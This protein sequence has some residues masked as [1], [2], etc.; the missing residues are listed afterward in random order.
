MKTIEIF[1]NCEFCDTEFPTSRSTAKFCSNTCRTKANNQR[2]ENEKI[3]AQKAIEQAE[4]DELKRKASED[5]KIKKAEKAAASAEKQRIDEQK[6][7]DQKDKEAADLVEKQR[8]AD[9]AIEKQRLKKE[10]D[11]KQRKADK[12][13]KDKVDKLR[14]TEEAEANANKILIVIYAAIG[15]YNYIKNQQKAP[16]INCSSENA[17]CQGNLPSNRFKP[18][19]SSYQTPNFDISSE[20]MQS[21][22]FGPGPHN[23]SPPIKPPKGFISSW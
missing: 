6:I 23:T 16:K 21:P 1:K 17:P 19:L 20:N 9:E 15:V 3:E 22:A 13:L 5:R 10:A 2:R 4:K 8:I 7:Q 14:I 18:Y 11:E 12:E